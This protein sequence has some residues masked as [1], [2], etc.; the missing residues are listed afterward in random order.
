[1]KKGG[2]GAIRTNSS[3]TSTFNITV[4]DSVRSLYVTID[5]AYVRILIVIGVDVY[6]LTIGLSGEYYKLGELSYNNEKIIY[7]KPLD[8]D[9]ITIELITGTVNTKVDTNNTVLMNNLRKSS[10]VEDV[11][12]TAA[13]A[14]IGET[15]VI[16]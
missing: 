16:S 2:D 5:E 1:M 13:T 6:G 12:D 4:G 8:A 11:K 7:S 3:F 14:A 9:K 15:C 10:G